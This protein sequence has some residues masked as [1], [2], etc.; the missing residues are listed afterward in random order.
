MSSFNDFKV[1]D[2]ISGKQSFP[3]DNDWDHLALLIAYLGPPPTDF[4]RRSE[5]SLKYF[6]EKG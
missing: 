2:L 3:V 5:A 1:A 4:L 6:T